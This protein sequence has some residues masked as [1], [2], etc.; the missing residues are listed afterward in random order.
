V[1]GGYPE[2]ERPV[3]ER[4]VAGAR[5]Y[6]EGASSPPPRERSGPSTV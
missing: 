2:S 4:P 3:P 5:G 6:G 1:S